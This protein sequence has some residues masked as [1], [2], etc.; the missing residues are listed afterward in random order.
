MVIIGVAL[1]FVDLGVRWSKRHKVVSILAE[2]SCWVLWVESFALFLVCLGL[3]V[4]LWGSHK[5]TFFARQKTNQLTI[6]AKGAFDKAASAEDEAGKSIVFAARI[7]T[8]NAQL[9]ADNLVLRSNV[10]VLESAVQW[11][12]ITATQES[13]MIAFIKPL[14]QINKDSIKLIRIRVYDK[15]DFEAFSYAKWL[16]DVLLKCGL[17]AQTETPPFPYKRPPHLLIGT[18][19]KI[20]Q[21]TQSGWKY[22]RMFQQMGFR[23]LGVHFFFPTSNLLRRR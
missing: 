20:L 23:L 11:R 7:G 19:Q 14:P 12:T 18:H 16:G 2:E 1:E 21:K 9:V 13:N 5:A 4:E 15:S 8:T 3:G 17:N 22:L 6:E 10:V